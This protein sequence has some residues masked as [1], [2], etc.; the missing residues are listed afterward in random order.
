MCKMNSDATQGICATAPGRRHLSLIVAITMLTVFH[1][2][3]RGSVRTTG[4]RYRDKFGDQLRGEESETHSLALQA[5]ATGGACTS[6]GLS[7]SL[8][9]GAGL[10][11]HIRQG[12]V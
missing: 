4:R 12:P 5:S 11:S 3:K 9:V 8:S 2:D 7:V 6:V 1:S 10:R